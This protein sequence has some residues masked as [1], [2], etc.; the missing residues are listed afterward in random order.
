[1]CPFAGAILQ[2]CATVHLGINLSV[3]PPMMQAPSA[4]CAHQQQG[5]GILPGELPISIAVQPEPGVNVGSFPAAVHTV[6]GVVGLASAPPQAPAVGTAASASL[7]D[8]NAH[9][10]NMGANKLGSEPSN[11]CSNMSNNIG[12]A[13]VS[14]SVAGDALPADSAA[15]ALPAQAGVLAPGRMQEH[16]KD[17]GLDVSSS[18]AVSSQMAPPS[19]SDVICAAEPVGTESAHDVMVT[20]A[21]EGEDAGGD[22]EA[23][24]HGDGAV[25]LG[26]EDGGMDAGVVGVEAEVHVADAESDAAE[27]AV[28]DA[29]AAAEHAAA[30]QAE[31]EHDAAEHAAADP[32]AVDAD[33]EAHPNTDAHVEASPEEDVQTVGE[34]QEAGE[35]AEAAAAVEDVGNVAAVGGDEDATMPECEVSEEAQGQAPEVPVA[36]EGCGDT[37]MS[38]G[39]EERVAD[40]GEGVVSAEMEAIGEEAGGHEGEEAGSCEAV[41]EAGAVVSQSFQEEV[42]EHVCENEHAGATDECEMGPPE[43]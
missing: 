2:E 5:S 12:D 9:V 27:P 37:S 26:T 43:L 34:L 10:P 6:I 32:A 23:N 25:D 4:T 41:D 11:M 21:A 7:M 33:A 35:E 42:A 31:A 1:M 14:N 8:M 36:D 3:N 17:L 40:D 13:A 16:D 30:E 39:L 28:T 20:A 24:N 19:L 15:I 38:A 22:E 18:M 29:D